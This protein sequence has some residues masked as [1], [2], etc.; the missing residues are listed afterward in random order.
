MTIPALRADS[1]S[2]RVSLT[3]ISIFVLVTMCAVI[4]YLRELLEGS[5]AELHELAAR[6]PLTDVGN[7]RLLHERLNSE[8]VRHHRDERASWPCC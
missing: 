1:T 8:L 3:L 7:Y 4:A 2:G 6:D 5:A